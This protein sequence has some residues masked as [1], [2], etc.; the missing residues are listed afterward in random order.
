MK[1][2]KLKFEAKWNGMLQ[3][4]T[5]KQWALLTGIKYQTIY[6]RVHKYYWSIEEAISEPLYSTQR[7][8]CKR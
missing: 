7:T 2:Y 6:S 3:T 8:R 1:K 5:L 4:H